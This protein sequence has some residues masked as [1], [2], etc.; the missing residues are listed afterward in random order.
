MRLAT[1]TLLAVLARLPGS[2]IACKNAP[3]IGSRL[4]GRSRPITRYPRLAKIIRPQQK[5]TLFDNSPDYRTRVVI[6]RK[7]IKALAVARRAGR[8][9]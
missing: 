3:V 7:R 5:N 4:S 9:R 8:A 6:V 2:E 1:L